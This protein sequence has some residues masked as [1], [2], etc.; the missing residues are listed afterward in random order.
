MT[1]TIRDI[2]LRFF[3]ALALMGILGLLALTSLQVFSISS[4]LG[5]KPASDFPVTLKCPICA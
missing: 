2:A 4:G 5:S 3:V 1:L